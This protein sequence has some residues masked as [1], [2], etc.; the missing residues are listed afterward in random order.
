MIAGD[1]VDVGVELSSSS[2]SP[3]IRKSIRLDT[4]D[5]LSPGSS[6]WHDA[7][8]VASWLT[9]QVNRFHCDFMLPLRF[10]V[11]TLSLSAFVT[12]GSD[13]QACCL[14][15]TRLY[16]RAR[17]AVINILALFL[18]ERGTKKIDFQ[19]YFSTNSSPYWFRWKFAYLY[20]CI[21]FL[22]KKKWIVG[23]N[24]FLFV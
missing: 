20:M 18:L 19:F 2:S 13:V 23:Y 5:D 16:V 3:I 14:V 11:T 21:F 9:R 1:R 4:R 12:D 24:Y 15:Y 10:H 7:Y 6:L 8:R 22:S 17:A